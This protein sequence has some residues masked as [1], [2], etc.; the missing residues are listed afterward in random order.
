[1]PSV[2]MAA[3]PIYERVYWRGRYAVQARCVDFSP[4]GRFWPR[5]Y[6]G[7]R[8]KLGHIAY[9]ALR[10]HW[11]PLGEPGLCIPASQSHRQVGYKPTN[12]LLL[13]LG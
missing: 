9:V 1:M 13:S 4:E 8:N 3:S 11:A 6:N 12:A 7:I 2:A 10:E 5:M